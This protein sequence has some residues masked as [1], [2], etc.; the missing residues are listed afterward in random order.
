MWWWTPRRA[1]SAETSRV[2]TRSNAYA[3][4]LKL[5]LVMSLI[6]LV[7]QAIAAAKRIDKLDV[8]DIGVGLAAGLVLAIGFILLDNSKT[9]GAYIYMVNGVVAGGVMSVLQGLAIGL[10]GG[11]FPGMIGM[12]IGEGIRKYAEKRSRGN[13]SST[14]PGKCACVLFLIEA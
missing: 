8:Y 7:I 3:V 2:S 10:M 11:A 6:G 9:S 14:F 12:S 1:A 4:F 5:Y 13:R